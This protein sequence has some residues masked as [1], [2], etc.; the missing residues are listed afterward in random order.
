MDLT[1]TKTRDRQT[2]P[3]SRQRGRRVTQIAAVRLTT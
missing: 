1:K 2:D 3:P